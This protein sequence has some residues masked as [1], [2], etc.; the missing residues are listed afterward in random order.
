[1]L[2][3]AELRWVFPGSIPDTI[4]SWFAADDNHRE[5]PR[6]DRYLVF[7]GS[8]AVGVKLRDADDPKEAKFEVKALRGGAEVRRV[9]T[10]V[11]GRTDTWVK[12]TIKPHDFADWGAA[13]VSDESTW[14]SVTKERAMRK[15]GLEAGIVTELPLVARPNEGCNLELVALTVHDA[16]WWTIGLESFGSL[17]TVRANLALVANH[18]FRRPLVHELPVTASCSFPTWVAGLVS[19]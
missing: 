4:V 11:V 14:I 16:Q 8:E 10:N 1:M 7:P 5:A 13:I 19:I 12:W 6:D 2:H 15:F 17:D 3:S 18:C 9:Y